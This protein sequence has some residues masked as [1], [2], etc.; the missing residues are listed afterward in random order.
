MK[1]NKVS[2]IAFDEVDSVIEVNED[3]NLIEHTDIN[4][5][6]N[7]IEPIDVDEDGNL[8][9]SIDFADNDGELVPLKKRYKKH[10]RQNEEKI[11]KLSLEE[12]HHVFD[13][14]IKKFITKTYVKFFVNKLNREY[15][16]ICC[17][18]R[19]NG[20]NFASKKKT[21]VPTATLRFSCMH[22]ECTREYML[23]CIK[24][25]LPTNLV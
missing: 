21:A 2:V 18:I 24:W 11:L 3:C 4:E 9:E 7:L 10:I 23:N 5:D 22:E 25:G 13:F 19:S 20:C 16:N 6:D 8:I 1:G 15:P 12:I 14:H 17:V